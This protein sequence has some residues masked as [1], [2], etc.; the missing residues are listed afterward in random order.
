MRIVIALGGNALLHK[1]Q[2]P[3]ADTQRHNILVA[4][5]AI[6]KIAAGNELLITHGNGP[7]VGLLA[8]QAESYQG[9]KPYP[10]DI[11]GAESEGMLGY[12]LEQALINAIPERQVVALLTQVLVDPHDVAFS[13]PTKPIGAFYPQRERQALSEERGWVLAEFKQ[14][15]RRV[16]P[17]PQPQEIVELAAIRLLI[18]HGM[19]V[20]CAGGGGIP[21]IRDSSGSLS[22][23]AAVIDK[24]FTSAQLATALGADA[25]LLLTDVDG[26]YQGWAQAEASL[27]GQATV[28]QLRAQ[29][30][31][32]GTMAPKVEA[33]CRFAASTGR[34]AYIG[35][36]SQIADIMAGQS[37]TKIVQG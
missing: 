9:V 16:V 1:N 22:G 11:L 4:A 34:C 6:A 18:D 14:G 15:L 26:L 37:G 2:S 20:V 32:A 12:Q 19:I 29:S 27:L 10:L 17:S 23:V 8:L 7:Q 24:D 31:E 5:R 28:S 3:E 36:L 25:L 33:A 21:V 30:F 13:E 35:Q